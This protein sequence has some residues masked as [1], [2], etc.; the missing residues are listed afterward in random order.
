MN[1]QPD[2]PRQILR[3]NDFPDY[4]SVVIGKLIHL[5]WQ[6]MNMLL[7]GGRIAFCPLGGNRKGGNISVLVAIEHAVAPEHIHLADDTCVYREMVIGIAGVMQDIDDEGNSVTVR[8]GG[9]S[10]PLH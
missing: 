4:S 6:T 8:P 9:Y 1:G 2:L 5:P 7:G 10:F 3:P